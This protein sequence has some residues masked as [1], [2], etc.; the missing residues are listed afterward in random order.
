MLLDQ[1]DIADL[2]IEDLRK[3][4]VWSLADRIVGL[5]NLKS[6]DVPIIRRSILRYALAYTGD[7][8]NS[9][10]AMPAKF[11]ADLRLKDRRW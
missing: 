2:A 1:N 9:K 7:S 11:V 10:D 8:K 3:W 4:K 5:Y 6:H